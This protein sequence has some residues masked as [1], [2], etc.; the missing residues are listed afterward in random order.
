[1]SRIKDIYDWHSQNA[2]ADPNMFELIEVLSVASVLPKVDKEEINQL[3]NLEITKLFNNGIIDNENDPLVRLVVEFQQKALY[4]EEVS[5]PLAEYAKMVAGIS[6]WIKTQLART[7]N[8]EAFKYDNFHEYADLLKKERALLQSGEKLGLNLKQLAEFIAAKF[9]TD[10]KDIEESIREL[11]VANGGYS[12]SSEEQ[13]MAAM[14]EA[15]VEAPVD[16]NAS[17]K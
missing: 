6:F 2:E 10:N 3:V 7:E 17:V 11:Q 13:E 15:P 5:E 4:K 1:M 8:K 9:K 14:F 16:E 12:M